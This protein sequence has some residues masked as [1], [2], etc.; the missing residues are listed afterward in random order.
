M[1]DHL[2]DDGPVRIGFLGLGNMGEPMAANLVRAG[3]PLIVWNRS[4]PKTDSL[5]RIGATT[6]PSPAA[7]FEACD[8]VVVMLANGEVIDEVLG[9][10]TTGFAAPVGGRTVV[11]MG[12]VSPAYSD[13]LGADLAAAG[14]DYVEA[15]VSGSR[16][17]AEAGELVVMLGGEPSVLDRVQP[18]LGPLCSASYRC[19]AVPGALRMKLAV[20]VFLISM[21][22]GLAEA[23]RF[24]EAGG[25][26]LDT[27]RSILDAGPMASPVS[28]V[29]IGKMVTDD[30]TP[31]AS[32]RD[33]GYNSRL[34]LEAATGFGATMPVLTVC[35]ALFAEAER[36]GAG[37]ADMIAVLDAIRERDTEGRA[38]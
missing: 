13:R 30:R 7:V 8:I 27:L 37:D 19:G 12:T 5:A 6:A 33:V 23:V 32:I 10:S 31:Q 34:V 26:D 35:G 14:A 16:L 1:T 29:K 15:P 38:G 25:S 36:L 11:N 18:M 3:T 2:G 21:V 9:R 17:P 28:R 4:S 24:A 22:T 20:N